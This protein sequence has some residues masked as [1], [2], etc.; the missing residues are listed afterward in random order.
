MKTVV[1]YSKKDHPSQ[2]GMRKPVVTISLHKSMTKADLFEAA[3]LAMHFLERNRM[4]HDAPWAQ[5]KV[6]IE[7]F[8]DS[9]LE[10]WED[11][12]SRTFVKMALAPFAPVLAGHLNLGANLEH[13]GMGLLGMAMVALGEEF[14][15]PIKVG[16]NSVPAE[17][18][19]IRITELITEH[20]P[21]V[22]ARADELNAGAKPNPHPKLV[23]RCGEPD[24][25]ETCLYAAPGMGLVMR[26]MVK[27][28]RRMAQAMAAGRG[29]GGPEARPSSKPTGEEIA[30][31]VSEA[32]VLFVEQAEPRKPDQVLMV[33]AYEMD[34]PEYHCAWMTVGQVEAMSFPDKEKREITQMMGR[35]LARAAE[36]SWMIPIVYL[37]QSKK[38][39]TFTGALRI[40]RQEG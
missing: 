14:G 1:G 25:F 34:E 40:G 36:Q 24:E 4:A 23:I 37:L 31:R 39:G 29:D 21:R 27:R 11:P 20:A 12:G 28:V 38:F 22:N 10:L 16:A 35:S 26:Q 8:D 9:P 2:R 6:C 17:G 13:D 5:I 7:G 3:S 32:A 30:S 18:I 15:C 33:T 19:L